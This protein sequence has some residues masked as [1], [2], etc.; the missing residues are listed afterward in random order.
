LA[1]A[2]V[3]GIGEEVIA[4]TRTH[5]EALGSEGGFV[6]GS[7]HPITFAVVPGNFDATVNALS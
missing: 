7:S 2:L 5:P 4:D 1:G 6:V 3:F